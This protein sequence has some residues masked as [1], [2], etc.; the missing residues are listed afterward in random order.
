MKKSSELLLFIA[1]FL[2][3]SS[4]MIILLILMALFVHLPKA[5]ADTLTPV[6]CVIH[7]VQNGHMHVA[8]VTGDLVQTH[9]NIYVV[10]ISNAADMLM[11][12]EKQ[13]YH[14]RAFSKEDCEVGKTRPNHTKS[15]ID[16]YDHLQ[17][18]KHY[19]D[20]F[21]EFTEAGLK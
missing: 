3:V 5:K 20:A 10:D 21:D 7:F 1:V 9:E 11:L 16:Y 14:A 6:A 17:K 2:T 18:P 12:E 8:Y 15:D 13:N 19:S 4:A